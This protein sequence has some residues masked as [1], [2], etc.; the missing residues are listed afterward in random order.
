P[1]Q[2]PA[3]LDGGR[4]FDEVD[5]GLHEGASLAYD[6]AGKIIPSSSRPAAV[7]ANHRTAAAIV[8][9]PDSRGGG[10]ERT[11]VAPS[12]GDTTAHAANATRS[13]PPNAVSAPA[14]KIGNRAASR[15]ASSSPTSPAPAP[16]ASQS[17]RVL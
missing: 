8:M 11:M 10:P 13:T 12:A 2:A 14:P 4:E 9:P 3:G 6:P 1:S 5:V 16:I 7:P 17:L 15:P